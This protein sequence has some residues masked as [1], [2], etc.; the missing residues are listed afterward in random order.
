[1]SP[2][3]IENEITTLTR[4]GIHYL[5]HPKET[6]GS[7]VAVNQILIK[8]LISMTTVVRRYGSLHVPCYLSMHTACIVKGDLFLTAGTTFDILQRPL[9][10]V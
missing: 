9:N 6:A 5:R 2:N 3:L 7:P 1:M 4:Y 10:V 8:T